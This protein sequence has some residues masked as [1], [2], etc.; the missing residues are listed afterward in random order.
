MN[1]A[2]PISQEAHDI[3]Q[4]MRAVVQSAPVAEALTD[5]RRSVT[6]GELDRRINRI[7]RALMARGVKPG[8]T[9]ATLGS[10]SVAYVE[11]MLGTIRAG[12]CA[13]PLSSYVT[14]ETRAAMVKDSGSRLLFV[15][16]L[17]EAEMRPLAQAMGLADSDVLPLDDAALETLIRG[18]DAAPPRV[19]HSPDLG[20]N[21]IY[22]SGTTGM[23]KGIVQS[24]RYRAFESA[25]VRTR[26]GLDRNCRAIIATPLCSNTTLFFLCAVLS[27]GG[28]TF[29]MDKF[30]AAAWLAL[31]ERWRAT[32]VVL[33]PVQYRR[34]LDHPGFDRFDLSSMRNKFCTSAPMP[35]KTKAEILERWPAGGFSEFYG[36][37][38]GGVGSTLR[39]HEHPGKLDTVGIA[40]PGVEMLVI[41]EAGRILPQGEIGEIVGR[42]PSMMSGYHGREEATAEA[43]WFDAEGRR[44]QRSGD[45]GWFD[46]DGFLHLLDRKKDVIIS[47]GFNIYAI[48]LENILMQHPDVMEAAVIAAP[49][50]EWGE[51]PV[52]YA[53]LRENASPE[54]IRLWA[55]ER[56][57]KAQRI[58]RVIA[59]EELPRSPIGKILKRELRERFVSSGAPPK[60][61]EGGL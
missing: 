44:Y 14:A 32:D 39:A 35:A 52:A 37:T 33:V 5:G 20:F 60:P 38:E 56:L 11:M 57:G 25:S 24:R 41:D 29:V 12:A 48:D 15:S 16:A 2:E 21:L 36:M 58:A 18:M 22:S 40:N 4:L 61:P 10:N 42:S 23:P 8:D 30:D 28:T 26:F 7:A 50:R 54:A 45:N 17:Y 6:W 59:T 3:D 51:T 13:V 53:V 47:G 49:S 46:T 9:V 19:E 31:A 1:S 27:A 55:N 43:S 34:L